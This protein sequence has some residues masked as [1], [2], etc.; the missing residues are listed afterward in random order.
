MLRRDEA[1]T[2]ALQAARAAKLSALSPCSNPVL[3]AR[4]HRCTCT[5]G[6][7]GL[8]RGCQRVTHAAALLCLPGSCS[9]GVRCGTSCLLRAAGLHA[10]M[11]GSGRPARVRAS[12]GA[13]WAAVARAAPTRLAGPQG[14][15]VK[16]TPHA[17]R[18]GVNLAY[19]ANG[20]P[21][22]TVYCPYTS[23]LGNPGA[24][25]TSTRGHTKGVLV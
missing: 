14:R 1:V 2:P 25:Y 24:R 18:A 10:A 13:L 17:T 8:P 19:L 6:Q 15:C 22:I 23:I 5:S 7:A 3:T 20:S 11:L 21:D 4:A 12:G 16:A 9:G